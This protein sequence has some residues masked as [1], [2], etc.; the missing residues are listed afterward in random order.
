MCLVCI[1]P[2]LT[3]VI[4]VEMLVGSIF[5]LHVLDALR[6]RSIRKLYSCMTLFVVSAGI[7]II[8]G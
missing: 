7:K 1:E 2:R 8:I 6:G 5:W 4:Y 3:F